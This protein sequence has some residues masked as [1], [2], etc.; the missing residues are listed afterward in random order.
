[1]V[2]LMLIATLTAWELLHE[3]SA[4]IPRS[5]LNKR[6]TDYFMEKFTSTLMDQQ[7]LPLYR[8][9]G[10]H[11]A[12]YLDNDTIE[13][14]APDAVFYQQATARWKVVAERGL[15]NSQGDEID[16]LGEVIIRQLGADSKT[17]NMK[18]LTQNVRVKPRIKYA[19]TQQPVTLLNSFGKTHSIGARVYLKDGRIELLSQVRGNYDLA[20]E[21]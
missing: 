4:Y 7:G 20:P 13:I 1:M 16:L 8:L 21:P 18:I 11:M 14:T 6:T 5:D 2:A 15:T 19:E 3:E 17:S 9:A 10:T 12:H